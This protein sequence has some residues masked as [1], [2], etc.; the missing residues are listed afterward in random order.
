MTVLNESAYEL[1]IDPR[2]FTK[3]LRRPDPKELKIYDSTLRDGEQMPGVAMSPEQKCRI[4]EELSILGCHIL[5][6]GFPAVSSRECKALQLVLDSKQRGAIRD[7]M[8]ILVMCR[9]T[10]RDVDVTIAAIR[11]IGFSPSDVTFLLFTSASPLHVKYKLGPALMRNAGLNENDL[12]QTPYEF[13]HQANQIMVSEAIR[14]A[15]DRGVEQIEFGTEDASRAALNPLVDLIVAAVDAGARRYIFP[16]TTGSLTPESTRFYCDALTRRFPQ[17]ERVSH[18]HNDFGLA[19][20]NVITGILHGFPVFSTT[21]NGIGERAGNAAL[22]TTVASLKYLYGLEIPGF[23][24]DRLNHIKKV[25]EEITGI[26]ASAQEPVIGFN[27]FAHESGIHTHGVGISRRMYEP[28]PYEEVGGTPRFIYGKHS[29]FNTVFQLLVT[30]EKEIGTA[31]TRDFAAGVLEKIKEARESRAEQFTHKTA[32]DEYYSNL[33]GLGLAE[34][35]II[36]MAKRMNSDWPVRKGS[37]ALPELT[38]A[39]S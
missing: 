1:F 18:F 13:F 5:D 33:A 39:T 19:T 15:Q 31:V 37:A 23:Q 20:A 4:A 35:D 12:E 24:Y 16:D 38:V 32:I 6:I 10:S 17:L 14:Y 27:A 8:E 36:C 29:G 26:P 9:A 21:V 28:I 7:D 11:D 22:H 34:E 25:V 3:S 2:D 30:H